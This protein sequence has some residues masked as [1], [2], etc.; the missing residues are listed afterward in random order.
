M[1]EKPRS[2]TTIGIVQILLA[3]TFVVWLIFFPNTAANFAWPVTPAFTAMFMGAGFM[4][5][6]YIGYYLWREKHWAWLRWQVHA[7][8]AFL[9]VIWLATYWH[10]DEM[11]WTANIIV[12]HIWVVA[13]TIEPVLLYLYEPRSPESK[14]PL[15]A[16]LHEGPVM[17]GLKNVALFGLVVTFTIAGLLF[18]NPQFMDTRWPWPLDPFNARIMAAFVAL[19]AGWCRDVYFA[20]E[21]AEIKRAVMGLAI[22]AVSNFGL[23]L[24][25]MPQFDSTRKNG[26]T[27]GIAF[28]LFSALMVYYYIRQERAKTTK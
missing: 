11:N 24:V 8:Y 9:L 21:W 3:A 15:P 20:E 10:V 16:A 19:C 7:N 28:A 14:A 2:I 17:Q 4:A 18:I 12:A 25:M 5:R 22:Y 23:W 13:Y 6:T 27:Y 1:L 26:Y